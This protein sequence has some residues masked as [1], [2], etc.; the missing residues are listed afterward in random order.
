MSEFMKKSYIKSLSQANIIFLLSS[1]ENSKYDYEKSILKISIENNIK[2]FL[3]A[4]KIDKINNNDELQL[5]VKL[6]EE[7]LKNNIYPISVKN[8]KGIDNLMND[9]L[10]IYK[11]FNLTSDIDPSGLQYKKNIIQEL[12]RGVINNDSHGEIPYESAVFIE[13]INITKKLIKIRSNIIVNNINQKKIIIGK[14]GKNIKNIG[15]E[16]RKLIEKNYSKAV[17][18][19]LHVLV[20]ENWRNNIKI[21]EKMGFKS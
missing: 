21:L 10:A 13:N 3:I 20:N 16:S 18:L 4:N 17:Y 1:I 5:K 8:D 6:L 19:E 9:V 14:D 15:I 2:I 11:N 12:I 7:K